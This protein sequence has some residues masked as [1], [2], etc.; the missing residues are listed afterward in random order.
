MITNLQNDRLAAILFSGC[1]EFQHVDKK[2]KLS[3]MT[4]GSMEKKLIWIIYWTIFKC[5]A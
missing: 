5:I 1:D 2:I 4:E 3:Q